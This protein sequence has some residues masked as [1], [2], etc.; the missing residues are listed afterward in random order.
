MAKSK[1]SG[2]E[3]AAKSKKLKAAVVGLGMGGGHAM[4]Y[5]KSRYA[6]LVAVCDVST[7]RIANFCKAGL[8]ARQEGVECATYEDFDELLDKE[9]PDLVSICVPNDL[10]A[11]FTLKALQAG[12]HV[13]CEKPLATNADDAAR[14]V[15]TARAKGL[16]FAVNLSFRFTPQSRFLHSMAEA[17]EF[18]EVYFAH[19]VWHRRRGMPFGTGWFTDVTRSGG[20]P[21]IDLGV[22]RLD[23]AWWLMGRPRPVRA[24]GVTYAKFADAYSEKFGARVTTEDLAAALIRFE[25]GAALSV[26]ASWAGNVE[27]RERMVTR[28]WGTK[29]GAV[30]ENTG[31]GYGFAC[32]ILRS[33]AGAEVDVT[34]HDGMLPESPSSVDDFCRAVVDGTPLLAPGEDGLQVQRMLDAIYRS[35]K[36][37]CEVEV[38]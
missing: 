12:A 16:K 13:L 15:E 4:E 1:K 29:A 22:H 33:A 5:Q 24:T 19:T 14:M 35:A 7:A 21:L 36:Q 32:R 18:G 26:Q 38:D 23:L 31:E 27:W 34:P 10:H 9:K 37:G 30:Q 11:P 2:K 20:G 25:N 8:S 3:A 28:L 17:G 6:D